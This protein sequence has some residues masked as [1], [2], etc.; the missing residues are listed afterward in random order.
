[1]FS[2]SLKLLEF[3][4]QSL[5][6]SCLTLYHP[7]TVACQAPLSSTI[8]WSLFKFKSIKSIDA[9]K[10][11]HP[12]FSFYFESFPAL[13]SLPMSQLFASDSQSIEAST[14]A[15]VLPMINQ[16][17]SAL[18]LAG[19]MIGSPCSPRDSQVSSL[20][21]QFKCI[22]FSALSLPYGPTVTSIHNY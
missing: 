22:N 14:L 17:L 6:K 7:W 12:L 4:V 13:G 20:T 3:V 9:I 16:T 11:S 21:P 10:P 18:G 15:S 1:M 19:L 5:D 8:S 2:H